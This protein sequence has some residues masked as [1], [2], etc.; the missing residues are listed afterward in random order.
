MAHDASPQA[1]GH[2]GVRSMQERIV[3]ILC[4]ELGVEPHEVMPGSAITDDLGADS[5]DR[6]ELTLRFEEEFGVEIP[7]SD[8]DRLRTPA[9][10]ET[11]LATQ[12]AAA[13]DGCRF[14]V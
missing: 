2:P 13:Q 7:D 1:D 9:D 11:Y 3:T 14:V 10:I 8:A 5:L 6:I 4:E 12:I